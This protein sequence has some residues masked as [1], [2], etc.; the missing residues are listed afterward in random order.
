LENFCL[1]CNE[2]YFASEKITSANGLMAVKCEPCNLEF[3][4]VCNFQN[5]QIKTSTLLK[6]SLCENGY[7][8]VN[9]KCE[10]CPEN[11]LYCNEESKECTLSEDNFL[12]TVKHKCQIVSIDNCHTF[13]QSGECTMCETHFYLKDNEC[14]ACEQGSKNCSYC[15]A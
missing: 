13:S 2:G 6:C 8:S 9:G 7:T 1:N 5:D 12:I 11:C 15:T 14:V 3:C 10:K 4:L